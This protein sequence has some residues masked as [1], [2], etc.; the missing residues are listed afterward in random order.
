MPATDILGRCKNAVAPIN[1][2]GESC[3]ESLEKGSA[4]ILTHLAANLCLGAFGKDAER[5]T[6]EA[7]APLFGQGHLIYDQVATL[8]GI[9]NLNSLILA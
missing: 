1:E 8:F 5:G 7:C 2:L 3:E 6:L 9:M 4:G